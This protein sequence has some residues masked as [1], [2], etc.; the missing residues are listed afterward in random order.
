MSNTETIAKNLAI[1]EQKMRDKAAG[2][3]SVKWQK[4]SDVD[5][6]DLDFFLDKFKRLKDDESFDTTIRILEAIKQQLARK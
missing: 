5:W 3:A 1:L 4:A 2:R 6:D